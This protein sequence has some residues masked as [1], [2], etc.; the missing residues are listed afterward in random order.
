MQNDKWELRIICKL[1]SPNWR[2]KPK[3]EPKNSNQRC[4]KFAKMD[5]NKYVVLFAPLDLEIV[6]EIK[7]AIS[8][9]KIHKRNKNIYRNMNLGFFF[10]FLWKENWLLSYLYSSISC[11]YYYFFFVL[12]FFSLVSLGSLVLFRSTS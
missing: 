6:Y 9:S 7:F 12:R 4:R 3:H 8:K 10:L 2:M 1:Q 11:Y 5:V